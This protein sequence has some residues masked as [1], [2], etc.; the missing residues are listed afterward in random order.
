ML[1]HP[2][3]SLLVRRLVG[4]IGIRGEIHGLKGCGIWRWAAPGLCR[5][6]IE[7]LVN[8]GSRTGDRISKSTRLAA[9][10]RY[11]YS[12][13]HAEFTARAG[14]AGNV[15]AGHGEQHE[16]GRPRAR[17]FIHLVE[18]RFGRNG[19]GGG[20]L[21]RSLLGFGVG[22]RWRFREKSKNQNRENRGG[23]C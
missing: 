17:W 19:T 11:E 21:F 6:G 12:G 18:R 23:P 16:I 22:G 5:R 15:I 2:G 7:S 20:F 9:A 4:S 10:G 14:D 3:F 1:F 13:P 8:I